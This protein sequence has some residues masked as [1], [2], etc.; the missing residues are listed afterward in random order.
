M[1]ETKS[2]KTL[3]QITNASG[4]P[5]P[6]EIIGITGISG[7][8][9]SDRA[10]LNLLFQHAH[11]SGRLGEPGAR[12]EMPLSA[13]RS[14]LHESNDRLRQSL[15]RIL[16]VAVDVTYLDPQMGPAVLQTHLFESFVTPAVG[17]TAAV[18]R[19]AI[20]DDL[21]LVLARSS[22]WGRIRAEIVCSMTSKYAIS[23]YEM[24]ALRVSMDRSVEHFPIERFRSLLGVPP[25]A[26]ERGNDFFRYVLDVAVLEVGGLSDIGVQIEVTRRSPRAPVTGVT[27]AWWRKT[28]DDL[29]ATIAERNA[30]KVGRMARLRG[31][32][33]VPVTGGK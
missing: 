10:T 5:K 28:G 14:S 1:Q 7:L 25:G 15:R 20:P 29:R 21:R 30:S 11:D 2:P 17:S 19:F 26:Y 23:L 18:V 16:T 13:I 6:A 9:A 27:V 33:A 8:E 12:W 4:Y 32:A 24:L 3:A 22:R 31:I